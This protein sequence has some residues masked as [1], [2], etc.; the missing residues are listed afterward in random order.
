[1]KSKWQQIDIK[2]RKKFIKSL[3]LLCENNQRAVLSYH[4]FEDRI[5][6]IDNPINAYNPLVNGRST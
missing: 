5:Y 4:N 3:I 6:Y 2:S 1:M